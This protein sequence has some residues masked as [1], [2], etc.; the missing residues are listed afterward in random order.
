M[1]ASKTD[2]TTDNPEKL[3]RE[4]QREHEDLVGELSSLRSL[5]RPR[6]VYAVA[7]ATIGA[8]PGDVIVCLG[9]D[10]TVIAPSEDD[11]QDGDQFTV[12]RSETGNVTTLSSTGELVQG[13]ASNVLNTAGR[14]TYQRANG[15]WWCHV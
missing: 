8:S 10:I 13:A 12:V 4:L 3:R 2:F 5:L 9:F 6:V 11:S 7:A 1:L 15:G 14:R